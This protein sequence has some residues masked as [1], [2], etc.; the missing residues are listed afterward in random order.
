MKR[1]KNKTSSTDLRLVPEEPIVE[2]SPDGF[3]LMS[4]V[5]LLKQELKADGSDHAAIAQHF[6]F[7]AVTAA[8]QLCRG[9]SDKEC[10]EVFSHFLGMAFEMWKDC[11]RDVALL[12]EAESKPI[13]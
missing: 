11:T 4:K 5:A 12:H 7:G 2:D 3:H 6:L 8:A 1:R 10:A 9:A 13:D